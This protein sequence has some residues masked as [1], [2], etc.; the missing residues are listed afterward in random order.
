MVQ[1][2]DDFIIWL[3]LI[4]TIIFCLVSKCLEVKP[5]HQMKPSKTIGVNT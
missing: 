4:I 5:V 2:E 3:V 1:G